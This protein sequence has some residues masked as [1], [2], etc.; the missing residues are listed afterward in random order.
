MGCALDWLISGRSFDAREALASGFAHSVHEPE[1]LLPKAY[2]LAKVIAAKTAPVS[3]AVIRQMVYRLSPLA[4]P[5][6]A[7]RVDSLLTA[8]A[9]GSLD[10]IEGLES[11]LG[12]RDPAFTGRVGKDLPPFLP[13]LD[14]EEGR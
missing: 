5:F 9:L 14:S 2:Q 11:F 12:R 8:R 10:A 1:N 7:Q 6:E 13:W 4:S 3:V